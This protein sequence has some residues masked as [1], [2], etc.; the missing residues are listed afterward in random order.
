MHAD[1]RQR[2]SI[3]DGLRRKEVFE[4]RTDEGSALA[5][6]RIQHH[7]HSASAREI[8]AKRVELRLDVA[9]GRPGDDD[10]IG[11]GRNRRLAERRPLVEQEVVLGQEVGCLVETTSRELVERQLAMTCGEENCRLTVFDQLEH[12]TGKGLLT[13]EARHLR[14]LTE[15]QARVVVVREIDAFHNPA[16]VTG[17]EYNDLDLR[18]LEAIDQLLSLEQVSNRVDDPNRETR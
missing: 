7:Q 14:P 16:V 9:T 1:S 3:W 8:V 6:H 17:P 18:Q 13:L 15:L 5:Q 12:G 11:L 2:D 4:A 10:E